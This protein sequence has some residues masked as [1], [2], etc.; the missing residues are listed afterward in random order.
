MVLTSMQIRGMED[1]YRILSSTNTEINPSAY[2]NLTLNQFLLDQNREQARN[3]IASDMPFFVVG[4]LMKPYWLRNDITFDYSGD[5]IESTLRDT[6]L[7]NISL[8]SHSSLQA[9]K[10]FQ[11]DNFLNFLA[12]KKT[13][14]RDT[15]P[16]EE[17]L[18]EEQTETTTEEIPQ[19][20]EVTP[21]EQ[22]DQ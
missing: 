14:T 17:I 13:I 7:K 12:T 15:V 20:D 2:N 22:I 19:A 11:K 21:P 18:L 5:Y 8:V 3:I 6:I 10:L 4:Q 1:I 9:S 16:T